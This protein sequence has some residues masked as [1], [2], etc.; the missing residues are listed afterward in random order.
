LLRLIHF[1]VSEGSGKGGD[2]GAW[3]CG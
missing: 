1:E 2:G 3:E